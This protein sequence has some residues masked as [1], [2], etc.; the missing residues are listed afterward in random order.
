MI[1]S[2][3]NIQS[4]NGLYLHDMELLDIRINYFEHKVEIL[5]NDQQ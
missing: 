1:I 5:L 2:K 3:K 4:F